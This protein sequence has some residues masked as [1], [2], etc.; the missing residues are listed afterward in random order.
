MLLRMPLTPTT[1]GLAS[2]L[3]V[4]LHPLASVRSA[5]LWICV[6]HGLFGIEATTPVQ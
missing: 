3:S 6:R 4:S 2:F 1:H 5:F